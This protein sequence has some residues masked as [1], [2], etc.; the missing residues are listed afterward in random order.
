MDVDSLDGESRTPLHH[1]AMFGSEISVCY[2]VSYN[3][4]INAKDA[5]KETPLHTAIK[6]YKTNPNIDCVK[7]LLLNGADRDAVTRAGRT[8]YDELELLKTDSNPDLEEDIRDMKRVIQEKYGF[9]HCLMIR[10]HYSKPRMSSL[11][12]VLYF[13]FMI[14]SMTLL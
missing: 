8:P 6:N 1:A 13:V 3:G 12:L 5:Q 14:L 10:N 7:K 4:Y 11:T 2:L 9:L